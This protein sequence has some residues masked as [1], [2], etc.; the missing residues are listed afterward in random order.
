MPVMLGITWSINIM[1]MGA[2]VSI[3]CLVIST[4]IAPSE[5]Y[6]QTP[7]ELN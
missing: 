1:S 7:S 6:N 4:A 5:A 2:P 3:D